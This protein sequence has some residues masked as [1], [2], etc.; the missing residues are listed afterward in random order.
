VVPQRWIEDIL[1][2]DGTSAWTSGD[3]DELFAGADMHYR[4]QW[5][6]LRGARPLIFGVGVF[7]QHIFVD[8][9]ADW[10]MAKC[11]SQPLPLDPAFLSMTLAGV[12]RLRSLGL[13]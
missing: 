9:A 13:A 8:P 5:Y 4:S 6:V 2:F 11:S 10:V 1:N 3:F 7:G 12:E